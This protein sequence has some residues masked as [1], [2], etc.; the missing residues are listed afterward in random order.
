VKRRKGEE[1]RRREEATKRIPPLK[2]VR[3]ML[4]H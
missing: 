4:I 2:G 1:K 3:G